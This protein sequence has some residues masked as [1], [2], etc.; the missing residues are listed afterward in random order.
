[1]TS[2][3]LLL[4]LLRL[5][6]LYAGF[7]TDARIVHR[8][9]SQ[10]AAQHDTMLAT[11][12]LLSLDVRDR[13]GQTAPL[14]GGQSNTN[15]ASQAEQRLPALYPQ[16]LAVERSVSDSAWTT[17]AQQQAAA[18]SRQ[19]GRPVLADVRPELGSYLLIQA[20]VPVSH[21]LRID[22][23]RLTPGAPDWIDSS[24]GATRLSLRLGDAAAHLLQAGR[25]SP[26]AWHVVLHKPLASASQPFELVAE[27]WFGAADLPWLGAGVWLLCCVGLLAGLR[28][29][30]RLRLGRQRAEELLRLGQVARL[31]TLGELAAGMAHELNQPLTAV[32]SSTQAALRLLSDEP[33]EGP[34]VH[35]LRQ[36]LQHAVAQAKR[37]SEVLKRLRRMVERPGSATQVQPLSLLGAVHDTLQL[38]EPEL[39]S[40]EVKLQLTGLLHPNST[41]AV[42]QPTDTQVLA[43]PVALQQV[44]HNLLM[45]ALQALEQ[46]PPGGRELTVGVG[47]RPARVAMTQHAQQ[48]D[49]GAAA[50]VD[51]V[52]DLGVVEVSDSGPGISPEALPHVFEPF[53][54]TRAG[55][56]G[57]GLSLCETLVTAMGG[58]LVAANRSPRGALFTLSLARTPG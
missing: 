47:R 1:M 26:W 10:K 45:N 12:N 16:V 29:W 33:H 6:G 38:L 8:L 22:L 19:L 53:Y 58:Q 54:T 37:A 14:T 50:E 17:A 43:D 57:L 24:D 13:T 4:A 40:R 39:R 3:L 30:Q 42:G 20:G 48:G 7:E 34:D 18:S 51:G 23:H 46:V 11:L 55:G 9:L 15:A 25:P 5:Q 41:H 32:L 52:G 49:P 21:G 27:R 56:L 44:V 28:A 35:L 36:A 2:G 31:N